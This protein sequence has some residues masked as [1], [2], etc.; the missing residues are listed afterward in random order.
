MRAKTGHAG[1]IVVPFIMSG[2]LRANLS[3]TNFMPPNF[4]YNF[5]MLLTGAL[6]GFLSGM[7]GVGGSSVATPVLRLLDVPRLLALGTPL[8]VT[9][10]TAL[11]GGWTYWRR[12]LVN[13]RA[14]L[15][16]AL[17][18]VPADIAGS[19]LTA[20]VPG[21]LLMT[22]TGAFVV[23]VGARLLWKPILAPKTAGNDTEPARAA[24]TAQNT[25]EHNAAKQNTDAASQ[26]DAKHA[27]GSPL[28]FLLV[29]LVVGFLSGLL[30]NGGGFLL[31]PAYL[32]LFGMSAQEAAGTSLVAVALLALPGTYVHWRLGHVDARLALLLSLG[33]IPATYAGARAGIG[34]DARKSRF[35]FGLFLLV[36]G[37]FFLART[38][39]RAELYGWLE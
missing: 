8:P 16:T 33:V 20:R 7:F 9:L 5:A 10:P 30:A 2:L 39:Y 36:F 13:G 3:D 29:G 35:A 4:K 22:L 12:G 28:K 15:W 21:R 34:L 23:I 38:V 17:G 32:L 19:Y 14:A 1:G 6:L 27:A 31:V 11:V 24:D 18:G 25:E 37:V 26:G